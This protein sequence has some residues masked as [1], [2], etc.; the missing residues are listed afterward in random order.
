MST[1]I[2]FPI[3]SEIPSR[4]PN[5][6][7]FDPAGMCFNSNIIILYTSNSRHC[8]PKTY[9]MIPAFFI[10]ATSSGLYPSAASG[11]R[12]YE[13]HVKCKKWSIVVFVG[14]AGQKTRRNTLILCNL[15]D[16]VLIIYLTIVLTIPSGC[17]AHSSPLIFF[18]ISLSAPSFASF[19]A[20]NSS[21]IS[22]MGQYS[23]PASL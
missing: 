13:I 1:G 4:N 23:S 12:L 18:R 11:P 6:V 19:K 14:P 20:F 10:R 3:I 17:F 9:P 16:K 15:F 21:T 22:T 8:H 2:L 7:V 5:I